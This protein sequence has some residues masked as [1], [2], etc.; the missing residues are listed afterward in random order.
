MDTE[1]VDVAASLPDSGTQIIAFPAVVDSGNT[2]RI[3]ARLFAACRPNAGVVIADLSQT[4]FLD[5]FGMRCLLV[6][7]DQALVCGAELRIVT[8]SPAVLRVLEL[9]GLEGKLRVYST[10]DDAVSDDTGTLRD[11]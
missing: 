1:Y 9:A 10:I 7:A 5:T 11:A 8:R 2:V 3:A 6:A 4:E